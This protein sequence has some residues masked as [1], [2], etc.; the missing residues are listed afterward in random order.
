MDLKGIDSKSSQQ[1]CFLFRS[2]VSSCRIQPT[3][4]LM[5][6]VIKDI[7]TKKQSLQAKQTCASWLMTFL[8][9]EAKVFKSA[10]IGESLLQLLVQRWPLRTFCEM[11]IRETN[12]ARHQRY[13]HIINNLVYGTIY[14]VHILPLQCDSNVS[15]ITYDRIKSNPNVCKVGHLCM[16]L[17][18]NNPRQCTF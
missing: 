16:A 15:I 2:P 9:L 13:C 5:Y 11:A 7:Q 4:F 12:I 10:K 17:C 6:N 3:D 1:L 8:K 14:Y 18:K